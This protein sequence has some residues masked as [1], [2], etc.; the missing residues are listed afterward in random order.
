METQPKVTP[1]CDKLKNRDVNFT[2]RLLQLFGRPLVPMRCETSTTSGIEQC[3]WGPVIASRRDVFGAA[4]PHH[5]PL[6]SLSA[7]LTE[8]ALRDCYETDIRSE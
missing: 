6:L 1:S 3:R 2:F 4:L 8:G 5:R 7:L